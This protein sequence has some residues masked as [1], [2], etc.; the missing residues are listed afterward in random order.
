MTEKKK[1]VA[2]LPAFAKIG[3]VG[4]RYSWELEALGRHDAEI[5][6]VVAKTEADFIAGARDADAILPP[7]G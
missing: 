2:T 5:V 4:K 1:V 3:D 7:G 6:E